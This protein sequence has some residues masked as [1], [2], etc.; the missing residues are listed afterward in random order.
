MSS[1]AF[2][3]NPNFIN[4][5]NRNDT[6]L[7]QYIRQYALTPLDQKGYRGGHD[8][9]VAEA[10]S[11]KTSVHKGDSRFETWI[12]KD[13]L[14]SLRTGTHDEDTFFDLNLVLDDPPIGP[15]GWGGFLEH[16][17]SPRTQK[18]LFG[19]VYSA[20]RKAKR[21]LGKVDT[22]WCRNKPLSSMPSSAQKRVYDYFG[23]VAHL[24][25]DM[26]VPSHTTND[27]H[28]F[29][30]P[31]ETYVDQHWNEIV[32]SQAFARSVN[33]ESYQS[34]AYEFGSDLDPTWAME[35]LADLSSRRPNEEQMVDRFCCDK[36][37]NPYY[38]INQERVKATANEL[39]PEAIKYTAGYID[40]I[41]RNVT[42]PSLTSPAGRSSL[43]SEEDECNNCPATIS[44]GNDNPDDRYDVS[45]P[46]FWEDEMGVSDTQLT[47][48]VMPTAMKKGYMGVW[49]KKRAIELMVMGRARHATATA[50]EIDRYG[51]EFKA[52]QAELERRSAEV[53][54]AGAPDVALLA[55]GYYRAAASLLLK[56][57]APFALKDLSFDPAMA[58]DHP[59]LLVPTGGL[60]GLERSD[61]LKA[62][63]D[64][65]VKNGGT[66]IVF[67][68]QRGSQWALL[69]VPGDPITGSPTSVGGF[70]YQQDQSCHQYSVFPEGDHPVLSSFSKWP[71]SIGV[72]G[73]FTS[74]PSG[75][76]VLL[77][78]T[79]N[80][81]P[82]LIAYGHGS[83]MIIAGTFYPDFAFTQSQAAAEEIAMAAN[84]IA[85]AKKPLPLPGADPGG[86]IVLNLPVANHGA[87]SA[88]TAKVSV[89][90]AARSRSLGDQAVPLALAAG[91]TGS[92][93]VPVAVQA[94]APPG[95]Y[96]AD[97]AL[98]D[99]ESRVVQPVTESDEGRFVVTRPFDNPFKTGEF[100]FSVQ[101]DAEQYGYRTPAL[102]TVMGWNNS[103]EETNVVFDYELVHL[104]PWGATT[105]SRKAFIVPPRSSASFTIAVPE[106][107]HD[108]Y[109]YG[110]FSG[111]GGRQL[112]VG[113]KG[114]WLLQSHITLSG[115]TERFGYSSGETVRLPL[116]VRNGRKSAFAGSLVIRATDNGGATIFEDTRP[117]S[118]ASQ[119]TERVDVAIPLGADAAA[120]SY[121]VLADVLDQAGS[122]AASLVCGFVVQKPK[123]DVAVGLPQPFSL[124]NHIVFTVTNKGQVAGGTVPFLVELKAR[125]GAVVWSRQYTVPS[126]APGASVVF[127]A[128]IPLSH[129]A[130]GGYSLFH[131]IAYGD[132]DQQ[133]IIPIP[134]EVHVRPSP[135]KDSYRARDTA[136]LTVGLSN[137]G[138]FDFPTMELLLEVPAWGYADK[139]TL[140]LPRGAT[141]SEI[142]SIL[143]PASVTAGLHEVVATL[144][145]P[146]G[147][148]HSH[149]LRLS[150][151][152]PSLRLSP[153]GSGP[154]RAGSTLSILVANDGGV[155]SACA[156]QVT[157]SDRVNNA[158][159]HDAGHEALWA[160]EEKTVAEIVVP[161]Q[162][163]AGEAT[164]FARLTNDV[165]GREIVHRSVF[166]VEGLTAS[167]AARTDRA[168][169]HAGEGVTALAQVTAG[170]LAI[171]GGTLVMTVAKKAAEDTVV[172][173][174][175]LPV[176]GY[177]PFT[178]PFG[179]AVGLDGSI[180]VAN[181]DNHRIDRYSREG[182]LLA[183][184]GSY[185]SENGQLD[186]PE[187]VAVGPDGSIYVADTY[188]H[189]V[190]KFDGSGNF[191]ASWGGYGQGAGEFTWPEGIAVGPDGSVYVTESGNHRIQKFDGAGNVV[192]GW[193]SY[194][195]G[196]GQFRLPVGVAVS[197]AGEVFVADRD[198]HRIQKFNAAGGFL[199][200]MGS[201]GAAEGQFSQPVGVAVSPA[202]SIYVSDNGNS[203]VQKF[204][205]AGNFLASWGT[206]GGMDDQFD[207][208]QG[209]AVGPDGVVCVAD[210]YNERIK[211][212]DGD[213]ALL[214]SWGKEGKAAGMFDR[215][216]ALA[217][218]PGKEVYVADSGNGRVQKFDEA[219]A[220]ILQ[221]AAAGTGPGLL[222]FPQGIAAAPDGSVFVADNNR[223]HKFDG[224][225]R[226]LKAWGT[227]GSGPGQF[228]GL[229]HLAVGAGGRLYTVESYN[230][231]VQV[232][233]LEGNFLLTWG[234]AGSGEG[235]FSYP[236]GIAVDGAGYV[237]VGDTNNDR[238]QKFDADG[239]F[240]LSW[241]HWDDALMTYMFPGGIAADGRGNVYVADAFDDRVYQ[242]GEDGRFVR[243]W[244]E[245]GSDEGLFDGPSGMAAAADGTV[246]VAE[247]R[248]HRL[249]ERVALAEEVV[250]SARLTVS[251]DGHAE[252]EH[253]AA[254]GPMA[255]GDYKLTA[256]LQNVLGQELGRSFWFFN[257]TDGDFGVAIRAGSEVV[258]AG[259]TVPLTIDACNVGVADLTG[260]GLSVVHR[261]PS[262]EETILTHQADMAAGACV[263]AEASRQVADEGTHT[264]VATLSFN[265]AVLARSE[266]RVTAALPVLE[267]AIEAP[268]TAGR[269][270]FSLA[271]VVRN[272]GLVD[273]SVTVEG[274]PDGGARTVT[275]RPGEE[276]RIVFEQAIAADRSYSF[277]LS[278]DVTATL[279]ATVRSGVMVTASLGAQAAYGEGPV[280][281]PFQL[282][283]AGTFDAP[284]I[285]EGLLEPGGAAPAEAYF[286]PAGTTAEGA[287]RFN[288]GP[289]T[290]RLA[291]R[292]QELGT[293]AEASFAVK[294]APG[295]VLASFAAAVGTGGRLDMRAEV[296][297][298][299]Y[300][301]WTG[302]LIWSVTDASGKVLFERREAVTVGGDGVPLQVAC[303][304][305]LT[306][307]PAGSHVARVTVVTAVGDAIT[308][309]EAVFALQGPVM[310][311]TAPAGTVSA[312]AGEALS[313]PF[314]VTNSGDQEGWA[315]IAVEAQDCVGTVRRE[316]VK[317]GERRNVLV[318]C[319]P[320]GDLEEK[321]YFADY[322]LT[323][324]Q[325]VICQGQVRYRVLGIRLEVAGALDRESYGAG[326]TAHLALTVRQ[327]A[328]EPA[329][330]LFARVR[331]GGWEERWD[332]E[333]AEEA[334]LAFAVPIPAISG[335]KL[336]YGVYHESG[337]ALH[338]NS[339]FVYGVGG[340]LTVR[341]DRQVYG[342]G[343]TIAVTVSGPAGGTLTLTGPGGQAGFG[344]GEAVFE[345]TVPFSGSYSRSWTLP[346][347]AAAG[348]YRV[349]AV[350]EGGAGGQATA[351]RP[352][353][354][355]GI[356]V[357]VKEA[358]TDRG[359]YGGSD[360]IAFWAKVEGS[361]DVGAVLKVW[362]KD[363]KGEAVFAG[364]FGVGLRA[365]EP[366]TVEARVPLATVVTGSHSL[367]YQVEAGQGVVLCSG[368]VAFDVGVATLLGISTDRFDYPAGTEAVTV[369]ARAYGQ[370]AATLTVEVDGKAAANREVTLNGFNDIELP[371]GAVQPGFHR[372]RGVLA[373]G[374]LVSEREADFR[375]GG[376]LADLSVTLWGDGITIEESGVM[377]VKMTVRNGGRA[378][379]PA[380]T[381]L[382][383]KDGTAL[384]AIPVGAL[385][386]G[387]GAS[388][389]CGW[390]VMGQA[391][392]RLLE[393]FV[394]PEGLI[395]EFDKGN[396]GDAFTVR[397]PEIVLFTRPGA[398]RYGRGE[399]VPVKGLVLNLSSSRGFAGLNLVTTVKDPAGSEVF[400]E[401]RSI[402]AAPGERV[403]AMATWGSAPTAVEGTYAIRQALMQGEVCLAEGEGSVVLEAREGFV[404]KGPEARFKAKKGEK[405]TFPITI[406]PLAGWTGS[407]ALRAEGLPSGVTVGFDP[408]VVAPPGV[409][410]VTVSTDGATPGAYEIVLMGTGTGAATE[411]VKGAAKV[412]GTVGGKVAGKVGGGLSS[413]SAMTAAGPEASIAVGI[414][415][416]AFA[417]A[418]VP[419]E[420]AV[421]Q[422]GTV[423]VV[424]RVESLNGYSG[425]VQVAIEGAPGRGVRP[426]LGRAQLSVPSEV[427]LVVR[428]ARDAAPGTAVVT[429]VATDGFATERASLAVTVGADPSK[430]PVVV[431]AP[432]P[433]PQHPAKVRIFDRNFG[434]IAEIN[435]FTS[436][437]GADA[438]MGDVDGDGED[439]IIVAPGPD[440]RAEGRVRVFKRDGRLLGEKK[441]FAS[442]YGATVAAGDFD[443]DM[444]DEVIV[445]AG[446]GLGNAPRVKVLSFRGGALVE[447]GIDFT[448]FA[449]GG[450]GASDMR[451]G[452][453]ARVAAGDGDGDGLAEIAV[454]AGS[455]LDTPCRV[456]LYR[457]DTSGGPGAW[458]VG[459]PFVDFTAHFGW[460]GYY[461][462]GATVGHCDA[463]GDGRGDVVVGAGPAL[464]QRPMVAVHS[465]EGEFSG[466][467][468]Q[469]YPD[470][471]QESPWWRGPGIPGVGAG[472]DP[473]DG[474]RDHFGVHVACV[475][476]DG[477][478]AGEIVTGAGHSPRNNSW[479]RVF[480]GDGSLFSD[481]F[482]AFPELGGYGVKVSTGRL[483]SP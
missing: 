418:V 175:F 300:D 119:A 456:A 57:K 39:V 132:P 94:D 1:H 129:V 61:M 435:A 442:R 114:I 104:G 410:L 260:A 227:W 313:F 428:A 287:L 92:V 133:E 461:R 67:T 16:F 332:F 134:V 238:V 406:D 106:V 217:I 353:D 13:A 340:D 80:G 240:V 329:R 108:G 245:R 222:T 474:Y 187:A 290:Y 195:S 193:G 345:E 102:F 363:P 205:G 317:A 178:Y 46:F 275:V 425:D 361:A 342:P 112:G 156:W 467:A 29:H 483:N 76:T 228:S 477:D 152:G 309:R 203:R 286:V 85:W 149:R 96:R 42:S 161:Q 123:L 105:G 437:F 335:E 172:F 364:A 432:G 460:S 382:F 379:A 436:R 211:G 273:G 169:Y 17:Y 192:G 344:P 422:R 402:G 427:A 204:D 37:G 304:V 337:R 258:K 142:F 143:V 3:N 79:S 434:Q 388:P 232:F 223:I 390:N 19:W 71:A 308:F 179:V 417:L 373:A 151:G 5:N 320:A 214:F 208:L 481:G 174:Q 350:V 2:D 241:N 221:W 10:A 392:D 32:G 291:L 452:A 288:L 298:G 352:I 242:F 270:P 216:M 59:V 333:L 91:A 338:L 163:A 448:A 446:L 141:A 264:F 9:I 280:A 41:Y 180:I 78:R 250:A 182:A 184:W 444:V 319:T 147:L 168:V 397:V 468:F 482:T 88:A 341:T 259:G 400:R 191:I 377:T 24:L 53:E 416:A 279:G 215:P 231:R 38:A 378:A 355:K 393:A 206:W 459:V 120:G 63:L 458:R 408:A 49:Y 398:P 331:Y 395:A 455:G 253:A 247:S 234:G 349:E 370:G 472:A 130:A 343:D 310:A 43:R 219:G 125:G 62:K 36:N 328:G 356:D 426:S 107:F 243:A 95:I 75:A 55:S 269:E 376:S 372:L 415:I 196:P 201:E 113:H 476:M 403:E 50:E 159:F 330:R 82:A 70:G 315:D 164:L 7:R 462:H 322:R 135:D 185:G 404:L 139:R 170:P 213:G 83:G 18:G 15:N 463:D 176:G 69:P 51:A 12:Q 173:R 465:G 326:E 251:Q 457:V 26:A 399:A 365:G 375:Y 110:R 479:V 244:G 433:G 385:E 368:F 153:R 86:A 103:D 386:P 296:V 118:A 162:V 257:V 145:L 303:A 194:G 414:D 116:T 188:N 138:L 212:F 98:F 220:F 367:V 28:P 289:G 407:V 419:A 65:Y 271:V 239:R 316:W 226:F 293:L 68:Q 409:T 30:K 450:R 111:P 301:A 109:L 81:Q 14:P 272:T 235:R 128:H 89:V 198:N 84:L 314:E 115:Q 347:I 299:G 283:N 246:L 389:S 396:N 267:A 48:L 256:V 4:P 478:G 324:A 473:K 200:A 312:R 34:G 445:G 384:P 294:G 60:A 262:G 369:R 165:T 351:W 323:G 186:M 354:I 278:G 100:S 321:E 225:G 254:L 305:D 56:L 391:G 464:L 54:W 306:L 261:A 210:A 154:L 252:A 295:A 366:V 87:L 346:A 470:P 339:L 189:R 137:E 233:D 44:P 166:A 475:D 20:P 281:I 387:A 202:G 327:P 131:A 197:T 148:F 190:Q 381:L 209:I 33:V 334:S 471:E 160:G 441:V 359:R 255:A 412:A 124:S 440:S 155:D 52:L 454:A 97:Y 249:Q 73:Y 224:E 285:V 394:D 45:D 31:F 158:L 362:L 40:A 443:G 423:N 466:I 35:A 99:G 248:N 318:Q 22:V 74:Y 230:H 136:V 469:A 265:G 276:K 199:T 439:E 101:S 266:R 21:Y 292:E 64:Q 311:L 167:T 348:T 47:D 150:V 358:G 72:D 117:L 307:L 421:A 237:Y 360:V 146:T 126:L 66:L 449:A 27:F 274:L 23:R 11:L 157:L 140:V 183:R 374:G 127:D 424:A 429:I 383:S 302:G 58:K 420:A 90:D 268:G 263:S 480:K 413:A 207:N 371:L 438:A 401:A 284:L 121:T 6:R 380:T 122:R 77:R 405:V 430:V 93:A 357:K 229:G 181:T 451:Y 277:A 447:T 453:G 236:R 25:A 431:A 8:T 144:S 297:N 171:A 411:A 177:Y 336:F 325:G 218:G 282:G